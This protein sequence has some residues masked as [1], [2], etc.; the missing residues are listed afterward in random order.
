MVGPFL[1]QTDLG[2]PQGKTSFAYYSILRK[3]KVKNFLMIF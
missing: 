1:E 2:P 3:I